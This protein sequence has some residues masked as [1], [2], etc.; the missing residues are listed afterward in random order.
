MLACNCR[1]VLVLLT[2]LASTVPPL[3]VMVRVLSVVGAVLST[4][5]VL[6]LAALRLPARSRV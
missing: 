5:M 3:G 6:L 4:V 1:P 2:V